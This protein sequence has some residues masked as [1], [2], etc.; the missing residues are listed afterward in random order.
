MA[1]YP[2]S[3]LEDVKRLNG[4][5][6]YEIEHM[7]KPMLDA[8]VA[9]AKAGQNVIAPSPAGPPPEPVEAANASLATSAA[10]RSL[11]ATEAVYDAGAAAISAPFALINWI[12]RNKTMVMVGGGVLGLGLV[13][14][15]AWP[16]IK[17]ARAGGKAL[18]RAVEA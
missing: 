8:L 6:Q 12:K 9:K 16:Y 2:A 15:V 5:S 7:K 3:V 4:M 13:A 11:L 14:L 10:G 1:Q 18:Q 17:A